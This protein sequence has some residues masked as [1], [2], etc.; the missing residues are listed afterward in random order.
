MFAGVLVASHSSVLLSSV[1]GMCSGVLPL[2]QGRDP[3]EEVEGGMWKGAEEE[4]SFQH[5]H[6]QTA[7]LLELVGRLRSCCWY[8]YPIAQSAEQAS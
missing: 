8:R 5:P 7:A 1:A 3:S 2:Q 4:G 6:E